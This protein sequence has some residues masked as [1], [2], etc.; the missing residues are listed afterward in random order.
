VKLS[1]LEA[2]MA[3]H[4]RAFKLP[5]PVREHRFDASRRWR[6]DFCWPEQ[7]VAVECEGGTWSGGRHTRGSGFEADARKYAAA[8]LQGWRVFRVTD[9]HIDSGEA[10]QWVAE[11]LKLKATERGWQLI[12][13]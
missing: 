3:L 4:I 10:V 9:A 1:T 5:E 2:K 7:K 12:A 13:P 6:F 8:V 11:A